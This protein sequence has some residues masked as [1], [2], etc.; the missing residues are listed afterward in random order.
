MEKEYI[1]K[2]LTC[3]NCAN[4][5]E[6]SVK[7]LNGISDANVN[8]ITTTLKVKLNNGYLGNLSKDV[9][10]IVH[11]YEPDIMVS[12]KDMDRS[13]FKEDNKKEIIQLSIGTALFV[14]GLLFKGSPNIQIAFYIISYVILGR[15]VLIKAVTKGQIFDENFLMSI[16]TIGAFAIGDYAEA[17]CVMLFYQIGEF[18]QEAAVKRSKKSI[19]VLMDIRPDFA[20]IKINDE[21]KRVS[22]DLVKVGD[23]IIVKPGEKIPLD[24][25]VVEGESLVDTKALTGEPAC[26]RTG[27]NDPVLSGCINQSGVITIRVTKI[28][29]ESTVAKIIDLVENSANKKS[30]AENFIT[31]FSG[32]YTPIVVISAVLLA[33]IPPLILRGSFIEWINR[34]LVFLVISCPCALVI[35]IPLG[36][37][38]GIGGASRKGILIKGGNYLEALNKL[39]VIV[40]DKTGTLTE[41]VFKVKSIKP[42]NKFPKDELIKLAAQAEYYS[43]HPIALSIKEFYGK[44][45]DKSALKDY[46]EISGYGISVKVNDNNVLIG[47]EKL[48]E[49]NKISFINSD[50]I[51]T[52][53][54]CA[55][56]GEFVGSLTISDEIKADSKETIAGLKAMGISKTIML[57]GDNPENASAIGKELS[58]D[59]VYA[60]LLPVDKVEKLDDLLEKKSFKNKLAFVGDGINDAPVLKMADIGIAMGG[61]GSDAAIEAADIVL[62]TDEPS[63]IIEAINVAKYTKKIVWQNIIFALGIKVVFLVLGAFGIATMWEAVFADV[64][65]ALLA[66]LNA[67]R[68]LKK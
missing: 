23:I 38:G 5:I 43:N 65:V 46:K 19:A 47:N 18:F 25:I 3:A 36:F 7:T 53:I 39:D 9:E 1:L 59:E 54:Y 64:G 44:N 17:V 45:I 32:F 50:D 66:V 56:N 52:K 2:G 8:L 41:G 4:K 37:F 27:I 28:F 12:E 16:A 10:N 26:K 29:G 40:F 48:L 30:N 49:A 14:I 58:L 15:K 11:K 22:P 60:Q 34:A 57:T 24:G 21:I 13:S 35:S 61:L 62:M 68:I 51:G 67:T 63:K 33:V 42:S 6:N 20:N 31:T 55:I